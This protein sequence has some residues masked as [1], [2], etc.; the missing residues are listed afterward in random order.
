MNLTKGKISKL[1]RK[2]IQTFKR[3]RKTKPSVGNKSFRK[4]RHVNLRNKTLKGGIGPDEAKPSMFSSFKAKASA[5]GT[6]ATEKAKGLSLFSKKSEAAPQV[7]PPGPQ[8]MSPGPQVMPPGPEGTDAPTEGTTA[9]PEGTDAPAEPE[10]KKG[11]FSRMKDKASAGIAPATEGVEGEPQ[12]ALVPI[13]KEEEQPDNTG[14]SNIYQDNPVMQSPEVTSSGP[15]GTDAPKESRLSSFYNSAKDRASG[16]VKSASPFSG[17]SEGLP[18]N[19]SIAIK[20]LIDY[21]IQTMKQGSPN[22][23][24]SINN[25]IQDPESS[26]ADMTHTMAE[27]HGGRSKRRRSKRFHKRTLRR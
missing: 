26:M 15:E 12:V 1:Y 21:T 18:E 13:P 19:V 6:S 8:V 3:Y 10:V 14:L 22:S 2:N 7:M 4:R 25:G 16:M 11:F 5:F 17:K 20:T 27:T 9:G 23:L 24:S